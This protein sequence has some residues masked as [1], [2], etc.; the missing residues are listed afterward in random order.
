MMGFG[1]LIL[2]LFGQAPHDLDCRGRFEVLAR[3]EPTRILVGED[4]TLTLR[5]VALGPWKR[6]P[7]RP[8]LVEDASL[9]S[10]FQVRDLPNEPTERF[11]EGITGP[12]GTAWEFSWKLTP[13]QASGQPFVE[14]IGSTKGKDPQNLSQIEVSKAS[15]PKAIPEIGLILTRDDVPWPRLAREMVWVGPFPLTYRHI[16]TAKQTSQGGAFLAWAFL[17]G[18]AWVFLT[19]VW[20]IVYESILFNRSQF[21]IAKLLTLGEPIGALGLRRILHGFLKSKG[22]IL[23]A[24]PDALSIGQA[25]LR[26]GYPPALATALTKLWSSLDRA[27]FG[28][29]EPELGD[30]TSPSQEKELAKEV[31]GLAGSKYWRFW[32]RRI[33]IDLD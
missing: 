6:G 16:D 11:P 17:G 13:I 10:S 28:L 23:T 25:A 18:S 8:P 9:L 22:L 3:V 12:T 21:A 31:L 1:I 5:I 20:M 2:L 29:G 14:P 26:A 27:A 32:K 30:T 19:I 7:E 4:V 24:E 15:Y 33:L